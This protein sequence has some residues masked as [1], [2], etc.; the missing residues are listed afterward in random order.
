MPTPAGMAPGYGA[1][2]QPYGAPPP[3]P[4]APRP[5]QPYG[6]PAPQPYRQPAPQ[7]YGAPPAQAYGAP[8]PPAP[9]PVQAPAPAPAPAPAAPQQPVIINIQ[10]NAG[11]FNWAPRPSQVARQNCPPGFEYFL[12]VNSVV[13]HQNISCSVNCT[14]L[15]CPCCTPCVHSGNEYN[16][17]PFLLTRK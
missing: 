16:V 13:V 5:P 1:P 9:A 11:G 2:Q 12:G 3:Q 10:Q 17:S 8:R 4:Y 6:A 15:I 7:A 14:S